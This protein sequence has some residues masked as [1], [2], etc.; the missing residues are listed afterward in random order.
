[1]V[2]RTECYDLLLEHVPVTTPA[3]AALADATKL[4]GNLAGVAEFRV[5]CTEVDGDMYLAT[6]EQF[7]PER[8]AEL[9]GAIARATPSLD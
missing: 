2:V 8:L 9:Q 4:S 3:F 7:F 6:A 1:M 5:K